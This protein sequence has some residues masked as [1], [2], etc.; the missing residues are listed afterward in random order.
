MR[1]LLLTATALT[2][3]A[4][5]SMAV[6]AKLY[7]VVNKAYMLYGDGQTTEST[8]VDNNLEST[9]FGFAAEQ[10]LDNGLTASALF[11]VEQQ[12]NPSNGLTQNG[13]GTFNSTANTP[14]S[15]S[16]GL[17]E[18]MARVGLAGNYGAVFL[19]QQDLATDDVA[20]H[21]LAPATSVM[22]ADI[23]AFGGGLNYRRDTNGV[24]SNLQAGGTTLTPGTMALAMDGELDASDAI[25]YN[26]PIIMGFRGAASVAQGGTSD[27]AVHYEG[28]LAGMEFQAAGGYK[29]INNNTTTA[30]DETAGQLFSSATIRHNS[31]LA[32]TVAYEKQT[33]DHK[34]AG[35]EDPTALYL[36]AGYAWDAF[37]VAVDYGTYKN[38]IITAT[39][40]SMKAWGLGGE[41]DMGSG[42]TVGALYRT[43]NAHV[44]GITD[45]KSINVGVLNMRVK[46]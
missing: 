24:Y 7:G 13:F 33:I 34:S 14:G 45:D 23:A 27:L 2:A 10:A 3:L 8:I 42:V 19:G 40:N 38:G 20:Y 4:S 1:N 36:K 35:V 30:A 16:P 12:S 29:W 32:A 39:D 43:Y 28:T 41:Y 11:E 22:T 6:D 18:R 21:D 25:R 31:G 15:T 5:T 26:T 17:A 44:A 9:R 37:G 46:F